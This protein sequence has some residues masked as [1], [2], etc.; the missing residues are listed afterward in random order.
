MAQRQVTGLYFQVVETL[1]E[2]L[3]LE[4][5]SDLIHLILTMTPRCKCMFSSRAASK[6]NKDKVSSI[7]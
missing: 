5:T 1:A 3:V 4:M 7:R 6:E 2:T